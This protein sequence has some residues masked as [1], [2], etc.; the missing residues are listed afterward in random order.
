MGIDKKVL[1]EA[2]QEMKE[3]IIQVKY[4]I[5]GLTY[6]FSNI[7]KLYSSFRMSSSE[8]LLERYDITRAI[9]HEAVAYLNRLGQFHIFAKSDRVKHIL[10]ATEVDLKFIKD[11]YIFRRKQTGHRASDMPFKDDDH[12]DII[13]L[14]KLFSYGTATINNVIIF[15]IYYKNK[16]GGV[17]F[18]PLQDHAKVMLEINS[19]FEKLNARIDEE[20]TDITNSDLCKWLINE[21]YVVMYFAEGDNRLDILLAKQENKEEELQEV[22]DHLCVI[23][24][25]FK[26]N[27]PKKTYLLK[28]K[29]LLEC[30][31]RQLIISEIK[32][33]ALENRHRILNALYIAEE[34][35]IR[36]LSCKLLGSLGIEKDSSDF[37]RDDLGEGIDF[38]AFYKADMID[39]GYLTKENNLTEHGRKK[40]QQSK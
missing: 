4:I 17:S 20:D 15:D 11:L 18:E 10:S 39:L 25:I 24:W 1:F 40:V 36:N 6:H 27:G 3:A 30:D 8:H 7:Q 9:K 21:L 32:M 28:R 14:D 5:Y 23:G 12:Y 22:I 26:H 34:Q 16:K 38:M 13:N 31:K 37:I 19:F 2:K 29:G 33:L 35:D